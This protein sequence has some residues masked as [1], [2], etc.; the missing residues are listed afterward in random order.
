L[1]LARKLPRFV[2]QYVADRPSFSLSSVDLWPLSGAVI[3]LV[4]IGMSFLADALQD[5]IDPRRA[6]VGGPQRP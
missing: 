2:W 5:A 6:R 1:G 3:T 4:V